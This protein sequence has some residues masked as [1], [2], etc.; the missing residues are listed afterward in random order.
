[1]PYAISWRFFPYQEKPPGKVKIEVRFDE[2][3]IEVNIYYL[4]ELIDGK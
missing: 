3:N 4:D 1:L 2:F